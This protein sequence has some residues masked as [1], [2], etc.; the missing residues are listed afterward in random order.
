MIRTIEAT[1][2]TGQP[3]DPHALAK[4]YPYKYYDPK[5]HNVSSCRLNFNE[6]RWGKMDELHKCLP[7]E[8]PRTERCAKFDGATLYNEGIYRTEKCEH[9][10]HID[11]GDRIKTGLG[12]L[13]RC[14]ADSMALPQLPSAP[15]KRIIRTEDEV[16]K[17]FE[18]R[19]YELSLLLGMFQAERTARS[20]ATRKANAEM[21]AKAKALEV[22]EKG[23]M[24]AEQINDRQIVRVQN[25]AE[26]VFKAALLASL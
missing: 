8:I 23:K 3:I 7:A 17:E 4:S 12:W 21:K 26:K 18:E 9:H 16:N 11:N 2:T 22:F 10:P 15:S 19:G 24:T 20:V 13:P 25:K 6:L 14:C 5:R 1:E